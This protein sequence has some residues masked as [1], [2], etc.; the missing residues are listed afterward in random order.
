MLVEGEKILEWVVEDTGDEYQLCPQDQLEIR[1]TS[2]SN[3][4]KTYP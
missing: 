4:V 2:S 3:P 1:D